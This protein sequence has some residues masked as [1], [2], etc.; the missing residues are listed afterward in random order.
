MPFHCLTCQLLRPR[1][2]PSPVI[3]ECSDPFEP[4]HSLCLS[5]QPC[6]TL[7]LLIHLRMTVKQ[8]TFSH[9]G[10]GTRKISDS[11]V[12]LGGS[13]PPWS[14]IFFIAQFVLGLDDDGGV[15]ECMSDLLTADRGGCLLGLKKHLDQP[16]ASKSSLKTFF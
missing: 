9:Q 1:Y 8:T 2:L 16:A 14:K 5:H 15:N 11:C 3:Q 7:V 12:P 10:Q 13:E 4:K 6:E